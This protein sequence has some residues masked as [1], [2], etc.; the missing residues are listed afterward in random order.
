MTERDMMHGVDWDGSQ[1][2]TGWYASEKLDGC[3]AYW[4][5]ERFWTRGGNIVAAPQSM[6]S[7][8]LDG[9]FWAGRG[10]LQEARL[11]VQHGRFTPSVRF[12]VFD[13]P[14]APG[15]WMER[16]AYVRTLGVECVEGWTVRNVRH[17]CN[18]LA[19]IKESGGEGLMLHAPGTGYVV[20]R[21]KSLVKSK[22][23]RF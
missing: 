15:D 22:A 21:T 13:A 4:D 2:V 17:L 12:V 6:P 11:A 14:Q 19:R 1:D 5:G 10:R 23:Q 18:E 16:M 3:R 9:E 8:P 7:V 20:G